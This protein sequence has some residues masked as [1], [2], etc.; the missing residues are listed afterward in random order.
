MAGQDCS[1]QGGLGGLRRPLGNENY[2]GGSRARVSFSTSLGFCLPASSS[3]QPSTALHYKKKGLGSNRKG[4]CEGDSRPSTSVLLPPLSCSERG[5]PQ[6]DHRPVGAEQIVSNSHLS[7]G[8]GGRDCSRHYGVNVGCHSGHPGRLLAGS[9]ELAVP[10]VSGFFS[11]AVPRCVENL[12]LPVSPI[13]PVFSSL[14]LLK[15]YEAHKGLS[16]HKV[17]QGSFLP[18]RLP[19]P[20]KVPGSSEGTD[21]FCARPLGALRPQDQLKEVS[22]GSVSKGDL[23]GGPVPFGY[24]V[25]LS[26][27]RKGVGHLFNVSQSGSV[28]SQVS[29][30]AR[31][32]YWVAELCCGPGPVGSPSPETSCNM[33]EQPYFCGDE[34]QADSPR[35]PF[36]EFGVGMDRLGVSFFSGSNEASSSSVP[37]D[38]RR[39]PFG[40]VRDP[41]PPSDIRFLAP[42]VQRKVDQLAGA[43]GHFSVHSRVSSS[44]KGTMRPGHVGQHD[45]SRLHS[46]SGDA[47]FQGTDGSLNRSP[48]VLPGSRDLSCTQAS[49]GQTEC[50]G[51]SRFATGSSVVGVEPGSQYIPVA[52]GDGG[53]M[54]GRSFC[55]Q[56]EQEDPLLRISLPGS[57]GCRD[58]RNV[59]RM[60]QMGDGLPVS[61]C[62]PASAGSGEAGGL[63]RSRGPCRP[64]LSP[65]R[66]V[67]CS[68]GV[69]S[70]S[71][72]ASGG[73]CP[74]AGH[75]QGESLA[76]VASGFQASRLETLRSGLS[77]LGFSLRAVR[78]FLSSH[79]ESTIRQYQSVWTKFFRFLSVIGSDADNV[80]VATVCNFLAS[81]LDRGCE[82]RTLSGYRSALRLPIFLCSKLDINDLISTQF[83]KGLFN[84]ATPAMAKEMP[85]WNLNTLLSFLQSPTFEPLTSASFLRLTQK[86]LVLI[87]LASGRRIRD[88]ANISRVSV[89]DSASNRIYLMWVDSYRA[90]NH[91]PK[92][93]PESPSIAYLNREN[94]HS[95]CPVR[96][97]RMYLRSSSVLSGC[98]SS[99]ER[100]WLP[101]KGSVCVDERKLTY[102][103]KSVVFEALQTQ[104]I[105]DVV[106]IGP[107]QVRKLAASYSL[108]FG[109]DVKFVLRVMGFSS[110]VIFRKNYVADVPELLFPCVLPGGPVFPMGDDPANS[111]DECL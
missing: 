35:R 75:V 92:F 108:K 105:L 10:R 39:L 56:V 44:S 93:H 65:G 43:E 98:I 77:G 28:G 1:T 63:S 20:V 78:V 17:N 36:Q 107:H 106:S 30:P 82:Y 47:G 89:E 25:S 45:S 111:S 58:Q 3:S 70:E 42:R 66:L 14:G 62:N 8:K 99:Q 103:F 13:R 54:P 18:G 80:S 86:T 88:V 94:S 46:A 2:V 37:L 33:D 7:D 5:G 67:P 102:L 71:G 9:R 57:G 95:L 59:H 50:S 64:I 40:L 90:K 74:V 61:S 96:A 31:G 34:R 68:P 26:T 101:V 83:L 60:E 38:D 100:L 73:L 29:T 87:L 81:E 91:T 53:P 23:S 32:P 41:Y 110:D 79:R 6:T 4:Y 16:S 109:Q 84:L 52:D 51:R 19:V 85:H 76:S 55:N 22:A 24:P 72:S 69:V 27:G 48:G 49:G 21:R 104:N 12:C 11:G 97:Y 15:G